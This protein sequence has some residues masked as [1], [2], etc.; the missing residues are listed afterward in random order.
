MKREFDSRGWAVFT[1][2]STILHTRASDA[3]KNFEQ[4]KL[5]REWNERIVLWGFLNEL[6]EYPKGTDISE[7]EWNY[8]RSYAEKRRKYAELIQSVQGR[9]SGGG[10]NTA[11]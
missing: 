5:G 10:E 4:E 2:A 6:P 3:K 11:H 7:Q 1:G 8:F 9:E